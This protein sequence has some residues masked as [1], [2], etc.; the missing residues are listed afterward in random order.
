MGPM[1]MG[2]KTGR[3]AGFCSGF[4]V[5]GTMNTPGMFGGFGCRRG[6]GGMVRGA[7]LQARNRFMTQPYA[8]VNDPVD[9]EK[10][11]LTNQVSFLEKQLQQMK[12]RLENISTDTV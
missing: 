9:N 4:A 11:L 12:Q 5:P 7:G 8:G 2:S 6:T 3:G 10:E 1:G